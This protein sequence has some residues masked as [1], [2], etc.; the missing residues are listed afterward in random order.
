MRAILPF[1]ASPSSPLAARAPADSFVELA[2]GISIPVGDDDWSDLVEI[3]PKLAVRSGSVPNNVGGM[4][5]VDWTPVNTDN[6]DTSGPFALD[7]R[8]GAPLPDPRERMFQA[9][10]STKLTVERRAGTGIDIAHASAEGNRSLG[11]TFS[12]RDTDVGLGGRIRRRRVV[13]RRLAPDRRPGRA[14]VRLSLARRATTTTTSTSSTR[15][16]TST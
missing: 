1:A 11:Q 2:G 14:A 13:Q 5:S 9:R 4:L 12:A 6:Q 16:T 8:L 3:E 15:A 7:R 10:S